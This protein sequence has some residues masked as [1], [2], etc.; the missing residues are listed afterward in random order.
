MRILVAHDVYTQHIG[1]MNRIMR[2]THDP[3][4]GL[5][6]EVDYF[7]AEDVAVRNALT[8]RFAFPWAVLQKTIRSYRCGRKYDIVNVHEVQSGWVALLKRYAGNPY[9]V[10]TT[11]GSEHRSWDLALEEASLGRNGPA[12]KT[13]I[14]NPLTRLW[15]VR[16]GLTH[17]D[18][19]FCLSEQ[20][21]EY[22]ARKM[23]IEPRKLVRMYPGAVTTYTSA[24]PGRLR[25]PVKRIIFSATWRKNKGIEDLVPAFASIVLKH[26]GI[27]L[28]VLGGGIPERAIRNHFPKHIAEMVDAFETNGDQGNLQHL[29][30]AD[31]FLLP[32]LLEGTPLTVM[33]AMASGLPIVTTAT[34]GMKDIIR[35]GENG[36]L[37]PIRDPDAIADAVTRLISDADLRVALGT[38]AQREAITKYTWQE[39]SQRVLSEY[40]NL[41]EFD[42]GWMKRSVKSVAP[43]R[44]LRFCFVSNFVPEWNAGAGGSILAIGKN[45]EEIGHSVRYRWKEPN[46]TYFRNSTLNN[47]F[48]LPAKQYKQ[49]EQELESSSPDVVIV[50]QPFA[51]QIFEKLK[52]RFPRTLFLNLTHGWEHRNDLAESVLGWESNLHGLKGLKR[53][54]AM[55]ARAHIC[56]RTAL[57]M[58]GLLAPSPMDGHFVLRQ[59]RVPQQKLLLMTYGLDESFFGELPT[60]PTTAGLRMLFFGQYVSRKGSLLLER[61]LPQLGAE[62]EDAEVTFV[63]PSEHIE[64]I[65]GKYREA[66]GNRL[67]AY[68]WMTRDE[69][70]KICRQND[71]FLYPS[72]LEGFGKTFLEAMACGVCVVGYGEGG[73]PTIAENNA[74]ALYC[75]PG[76]ERTFE[77]LLRRCLA[78]PSWAREIGSRARAKALQFTWQKTA[79]TLESFCLER[80]KQKEEAI[81]WVASPQPSGSM[82]A[83]LFANSPG[84]TAS[85]HDTAG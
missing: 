54:T 27:R 36:L 35:D 43:N 65:E 26:P 81:E 77:D 16:L 14:L 34:S 69:V 18:L 30:D 71:V 47:L 56:R 6:H 60:F 78:N 25:R 82:M 24:D 11:H 64:R 83:P 75:Q 52:E 84:Y 66:F 33:E 13:R 39:S 53:R 79:R 4:V 3:L 59:Y 1:G 28:T 76:D 85:M 48:E 40:Q 23:G 45:L 73:L 46:K 49:V 41:I 17:S 21:R 51:Y 5:G 20:D 72:M 2:F 32:S 62:F 50:S 58:D 42:S 55:V 68:G 8:R 15:Q 63:I 22:L 57:A 38:V 80:L 67:H 29:V 44:H 74:E 37:I 19:V 10:V 70:I 12:L 31:I 7:M 61:I 9:V